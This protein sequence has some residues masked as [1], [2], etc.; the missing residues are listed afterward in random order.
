[1]ADYDF[2]QLSPLDFEHLVR[3]LV[4]AEEGIGL[5][6]FK[7]GRD[8]GIDFRFASGPGNVVGQCKHYLRTGFNGLIRA[9]KAEASKVA[10]LKPRRYIFATS[11]PLS[12]GNKAEIQG[13]I[14]AQYLATGDIWGP[15]EINDRLDRHD[16]VE[17]RHYKLWLASRQVLDR[18]LHNDVVTLS[19]FA[20]RKV[21]A[22]IKRYVQSSAYPRALK[23]LETDRVVIISGAPGVGKTTLARMLLY[24]HIEQEYQAV[25]LRRDILEGQKLMQTGRKQIFYFDDFMGATFLGEQGSPLERNGDQAIL[26]FI[27]MV[28]ERPDARLILTTREHILAQAFNASERLRHSDLRLNKVVLRI[29]DYSP[30]MKAEILYNHIHFSDLPRDYRDALLDEGFYLE[31]LN[32]PKFNPRLIEWLSDFQRIKRVPIDAYRDFVRKLLADPS[33][34]WMHAYRKQLSE[35]A[36]SLLLALFSYDGR[37]GAARLEAAFRVL[38]RKRAERNHFKTAAEDYRDATA[39]LANAFIRPAGLSAV[40]VIDPSVLDLLNTVVSQNPDNAIDLAAAAI[41]LE[42]IERLWTFA[43]RFG[44]QTILPILQENIDEIVPTIERAVMKRRRAPQPNGV[45]FYHGMTFEKRLALVI[46]LW[47]DT[48]SASLVALIRTVFA[49]L[50]FEWKEG[51]VDLSDAS[52]AM[53]A[54]ETTL[55]VSG[56][57]AEAMRSVLR[58]A[59]L[60]EAATGA[61]PDEIRALIEALN[62]NEGTDSEAKTAL[63]RGFEVYQQQWLSDDLRERNTVQECESLIEDFELFRKVLDVDVTAPVDAAEMAKSVIEDREEE[64]ADF[65]HDAWKEQH[66][67]DRDH[68]RDVRDMFATLRED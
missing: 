8:N 11:V 54:L 63:A 18:V 23:R 4:Q 60:A 35:A 38:H 42:Q 3:D 47:G 5:E 29:G 15:S 43:R 6:S 46:A 14:G 32:H 30:F 65:Q 68:E 22:D 31:I 51:A 9:V 41:D 1:M 16:E 55:A 33:E 56:D 40:E 61:R 45:V 10:K 67:A 21:H 50:E 58:D 37:V 2:H 24:R 64:Y 26:D 49:R 13:I 36:R 52:Q 19:D 34:I 25:V 57:D 44:A 7:T 28:R 17:G 48:P 53:I 62:L 66:Y 12:P 39:E 27:E 59:V 20:V